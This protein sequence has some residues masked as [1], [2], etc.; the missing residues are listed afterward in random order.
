MQRESRSEMTTLK[1]NLSIA[2]AIL[3]GLQYFC[4]VV[5]AQD[6]YLG[7][8]IVGNRVVYARRYTP[9]ER[10]GLLPGD[11]IL[12]IGAKPVEGLGKDVIVRLLSGAAG[13][14][15][16]ISARR[17]KKQF[18]VVM[19][20]QDPMSAMHPTSSSSAK[21]CYELGVKLRELGWPNQ[22]KA[23]MKRAISIDRTG[24]IKK[25]AEYY[26]LTQLPLH[27]V[28]DDA[29]AMNNH[30][31]NLSRSSRDAESMALLQEC[32]KKYPDFEWPRNNLAGQ[33]RGIGRLR[34]ANAQI[35]Y[36]LN[37][38]PEYV[39]A[40]IERAKIRE[41]EGD[42]RGAVLCIHKALSLDPNDKDA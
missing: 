18:V 12:S 13:D 17:G 38:Y 24:A 42:L 41:L 39:H 34:E 5:Y 26:I 9:A 4:G 11:E 25:L 37:F 14:H 19:A 2:A 33:Y 21:E 23:S 6:G 20:T 22:S 35:D 30:A 15:V 7:L 10:A 40:W 36:I 29:L 3:L 27:E 1:E 31:W 8:E 28:A 16:T 32:V